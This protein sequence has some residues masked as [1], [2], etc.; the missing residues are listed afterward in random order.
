MSGYG[1]GGGRFQAPQRE[2]NAAD[3][4]ELTLY[5]IAAQPGGK[6][7]TWYSLPLITHLVSV[8]TV[9]MVKCLSLN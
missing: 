1:Q 5:G 7:A 2:K 6:P 3:A 8:F 9:L 4:R